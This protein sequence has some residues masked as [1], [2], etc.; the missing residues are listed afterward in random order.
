MKCKCHEETVQIIGKKEPI[1]LKMAS[2]I[3]ADFDESNSNLITLLQEIQSAYGYLPEV[4]L[5][6]IAEETGI[7]EAENYGVDTFD[8]LG[9]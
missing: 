2:E 8:S 4:V 6:L 1:D 3:L 7:K 9:C 5:E